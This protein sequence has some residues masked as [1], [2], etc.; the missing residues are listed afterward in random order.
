MS[1]WKSAS[2]PA[3]RFGRS[4]NAL[5]KTLTSALCLCSALALVPGRA[6]AETMSSALSR[7]YMGNPDLNQQRA[8]VRATDENLPR[9]LS[10][11][12]PTVTATGNAGVQFEETR[13]DVTTSSSS[14]GSGGGN[15]V[16]THNRAL[17]FPRGVGVSVQENFYN[18]E[19]TRNSA[20]Q[21]ESQIDAARETMRLTEQNTLQNGA[22]AYMNVLR[23]TA[24]LNLRKNNITVLEEQL[25]QTRDRFE[26]GEVTRTDVAQAQS[27]LAQARSDFYTAQANLQNS[28]ANYRQIIGVEPRRLEPAQTI[29][30]L[31][32]KTL[33]AAITLGLVEHPG[34]VAAFHQVDIAALN[35]KIQEGALL[36]TLNA[37]GSVTQNYDVQ[38][39]PRTQIFTASGQ[40][41]LNVPLYQGGIEYANIRQAK[42]QLGQARLNADL[43]RDTVRATIVSTWGLLETA[44]ATIY[45]AQ[46]AVT[47]AEIALAGTREE[48]RVGQRTTLDVLNAQQVLLNARVSLVSAQRDRVVASY[49]VYAAI[50]KLTADNL[51]LDVILYDPTIHFDQVKG[52]WWGTQTPDWR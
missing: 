43:Q 13:A 52:K 2:V 30:R 21:A 4:P 10:G 34:I 22:T 46:S 36:P 26:V 6:S 20:K 42:E 29:E 12:R 49:A 28:I 15:T 50:G 44:R 7:A 38:G 24:I 48:A 27:S 18:G 8:S 41:Q 32:P 16:H 5:K 31:L 47:A 25:R 37:V 35:V 14:S 33:T 9:A 11:F 17:S 3:G 1:R 51:A 39:T 45:S 23:D 19:R 40:L